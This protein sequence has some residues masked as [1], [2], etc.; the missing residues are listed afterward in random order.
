MDF[1]QRTEE[2][3]DGVG[4]RFDRTDNPR[5]EDCENSNPKVCLGKE[6]REE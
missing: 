6:E 3:E 2:V 5:R 4:G 1:F